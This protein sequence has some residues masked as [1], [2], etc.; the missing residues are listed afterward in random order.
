MGDKGKLYLLVLDYNSDTLLRNN[1]Y[2]NTVQ[3]IFFAWR[4]EAAGEER[5]YRAES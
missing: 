5:T 2:Y 1:K 3:I 4:M